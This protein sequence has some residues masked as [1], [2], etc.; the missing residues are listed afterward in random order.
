MIRPFF[1]WFACWQIEND[2]ELMMQFE[3]DGTE[4]KFEIVEKNKKNLNYFILQSK[5]KKTIEINFIRGEILINNKIFKNFDKLDS[6]KFI[7]LKK[8]DVRLNE[9]FYPLFENIYYTIKLNDNIEIVIQIFNNN[10]FVDAFIIINDDKFN[11]IYS[12]IY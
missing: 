6:S 10:T 4:N 2:T 11:L 3:D 1:E 8:H 9:L 12:F 5:D 7:F